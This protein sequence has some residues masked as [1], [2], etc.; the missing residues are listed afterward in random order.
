K[1][2]P[3]L[4]ILT[5]RCLKIVVNTWDAICFF[6]VKLSFKHRSRSTVVHIISNTIG[7]ASNN[8]YHERV[9]TFVRHKGPARMLYLYS[10]TN[11]GRDGGVKGSIEAHRTV[12]GMLM[13]ILEQ[14]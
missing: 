3:H 8:P 1:M 7:S 14:V 13:D 12:I 4:T 6:V 5:N 11:F 9:Y 2:I 10:G